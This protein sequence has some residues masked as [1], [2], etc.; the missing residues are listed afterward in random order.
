MRHLP[1][2]KNKK[3]NSRQILICKT[4]KTLTEHEI[5]PAKV[6][7][8]KIPVTHVKQARKTGTKRQK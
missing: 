7:D 5:R 8:K 1:R 2:Q 4:E 6:K 3:K